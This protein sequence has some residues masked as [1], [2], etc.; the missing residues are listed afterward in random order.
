MIELL[1]PYGFDTVKYSW[2]KTTI[3]ICTLA[4]YSVAKK[5]QQ[6]YGLEIHHL[7]PSG[8][9]HITAFVTLCEAYLGI[10]LNLDLWKYFLCFHHP[11]DPEVELTISGGAV[12]HVKPGH[13][14]DPY[15]EIPMCRS[16]KG[17]RKK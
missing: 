10:D 16:M 8:V 11:Q 5:H 2:V 6:Y 17:W 1:L 13:R 7:T 14:E 12:I 3:G 4:G 9:L 15:L